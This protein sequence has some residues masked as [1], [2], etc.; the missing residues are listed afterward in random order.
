M[1]KMNAFSTRKSKMVTRV[2]AYITV[3]Y[4]F[5]E[6]V[7]TEKGS[8]FNKDFNKITQ[9]LPKVYPRFTQAFTQE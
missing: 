1:L 8:N 9:D 5:V 7:L 3:I 2:Y 6:L 4:V